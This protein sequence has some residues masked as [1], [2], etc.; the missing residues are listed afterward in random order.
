MRDGGIVGAGDAPGSSAAAA[1]AAA[2]AETGAGAAAGPGTSE[3]APDATLP[4]SPYF[5]NRLRGAGDAQ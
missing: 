5:A 3:A 2:V 4:S 1:L